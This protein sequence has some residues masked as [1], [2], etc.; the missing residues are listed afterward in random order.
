MESV[1][2]ADYSLGSNAMSAAK[3]SSWSQGGAT[4]VLIEAFPFQL[5]R[6]Y[7]QWMESVVFAE[8]SLGRR[9]LTLKVTL[10]GS[11]CSSS[12]CLE[13]FLK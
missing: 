2:F 5:L 3:S 9:S 8:Y 4:F 11:R 6:G 10:D 12:K 7:S 13:H 1:V